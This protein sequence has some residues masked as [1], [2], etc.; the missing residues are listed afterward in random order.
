MAEQTLVI[1]PATLDHDQALADFNSAM[2]LETENKLLVPEVILAGVR[3]LI[4]NP[5]RGFYLVAEVEGA[6]VASLMV[7]TEWSDWRN[8]EFWW[9]QS[10]YVQTA[11]RR[12]GLYTRLYNKVKQLAQQQGDVCGFRLYVEQDNLI[13]QQT[14]QRLGM[15]ETHYKL[16]EEIDA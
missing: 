16:F 4:N 5:H 2:A 9:I 10:V 11:W 12:Q 8:G 1:R 14:Y 13:A 6:V 7:T 15:A 3:N